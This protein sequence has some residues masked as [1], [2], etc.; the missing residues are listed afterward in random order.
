MKKLF[1]EDTGMYI[2]WDQLNRL[3]K[4]DTLIDIGVGNR[5][6]QNLY[7]KFS[8]QKLILIDPLDEAEDYATK[9]LKNR[10]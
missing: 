3:P 5:G 8:N 6:T 7:E 10:D 4:I 2:D 9:N 1:Y